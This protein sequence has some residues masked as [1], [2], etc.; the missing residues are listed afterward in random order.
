MTQPHNSVPK[1]IKVAVGP[2]LSTKRNLK[3]VITTECTKTAISELLW[4]LDIS[5]IGRS[6]AYTII[7]H[8]M[9]LFLRRGNNIARN[10]KEAL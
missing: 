9:D 2:N 1:H 10:R 5:K 6:R 3:Q 4:L 7:C 8:K